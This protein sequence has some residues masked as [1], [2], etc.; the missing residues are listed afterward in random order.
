MKHKGI[1]TGYGVRV[2]NRESAFYMT[3][4]GGKQVDIPSDKEIIIEIPEDK[5]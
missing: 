3:L 2:M 4:K 5:K 1:V